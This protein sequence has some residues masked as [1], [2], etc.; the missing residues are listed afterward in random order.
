MAIPFKRGEGGIRGGGPRARTR[1]DLPPTRLG[2]GLG[3]RPAQFAYKTQSSLLLSI[4]RSYGHFA[5]VLRMQSVL[6]I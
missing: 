3:L 5:Y 2:L 1:R 6:M 4:T